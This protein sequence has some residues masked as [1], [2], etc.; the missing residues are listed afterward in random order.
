MPYTNDSTP[1]ALVTMIGV[2]PASPNASTTP[3][4]K[5]TAD[6]GSTVKVYTNEACTGAPAATGTAAAFASPGLTATV[7]VGSTTTFH[8]TATDVAGNTSGC[9]ISS[10]NYVQQNPPAPSAPETTLTKT[11]KKTIKTT[12]GKA[13]VSFAFSSATAGAT[14]ECSIDGNAFTA[15]TSAKSFRA[16]VGKHT[17][18]VRA[19]AAGVTDATPATY[20]FKVKKRR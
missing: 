14:F 17:F 7:A 19:V 18:A 3:A 1:P 10:V 20:K 8:A 16:K 2:A 15:C 9:S 6:A 13:K 12:K 11:P 4:V 5:G